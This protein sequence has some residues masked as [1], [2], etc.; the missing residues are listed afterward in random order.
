MSLDRSRIEKLQLGGW[1][2]RSVGP[3]CI[4]FVPVPGR[5]GEHILRGNVICR[6]W[7]SDPRAPFTRA[8]VEAV[9][10]PSYE[11]LRID[12]WEQR[13]E[14]PRLLRR[15]RWRLRDRESIQGMFAMSV[16]PG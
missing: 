9:L 8:A 2:Q 4:D 15:I 6:W 11:I 12:L 5:H 13:F 14:R 16:E 1:W 10:H 3:R 7:K